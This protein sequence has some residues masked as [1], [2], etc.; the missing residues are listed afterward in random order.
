MGQIDA[1]ADD[2]GSAGCPVLLCTHPQ[3]RWPAVQRTSDIDIWGTVSSGRV[4]AYG[5]FSTAS[6]RLA[7]AGWALSSHFRQSPGTGAGGGGYR[8]NRHCGPERGSSGGHGVPAAGGAGRDQPDGVAAAAGARRDLHR[9]AARDP[10]DSVRVER[11]APAPVH[12]PR[13]GVRAVAAR[14]SRLQ[15]RRPPGPPRRVRTRRGERFTYE[16]NFSAGWRHD[17]RV[18]EI[19]P[20]SPR[21]RYPA[22]TAAPGRRRRS[23]SAARRSSWR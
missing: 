21:R 1:S 13:G 18:E 10:A 4:P 11:R 15:P 22:C 19:L 16:Y 23:T 14:L 20:R 8:D 7:R 5:R 12:H 2:S 3:T 9:R 17:I 6:A